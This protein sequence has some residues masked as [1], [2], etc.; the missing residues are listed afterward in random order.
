[1]EGENCEGK[2]LI[3]EIWEDDGFLID[4]FITSITGSFEKTKWVAEDT[5]DQFGNPEY[6]F[7]VRTEDGLSASIIS[8]VLKIK[9]E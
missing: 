7:I 2:S 4:D 9:S 5:P 1:M 3:I 6:Y 8:D